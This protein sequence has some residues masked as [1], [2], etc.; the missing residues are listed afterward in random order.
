MSEGDFSKFPKRLTRFERARIIGIRALQLNLG[1]PPLIPIE[2]TEWDALKVAEQE[3]NL[4]VLPISIR[5]TFPDGS[6]IDLPI[7]ELIS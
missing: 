3:L 5:R 7:K 6:Y 2:E 4:G 1:A